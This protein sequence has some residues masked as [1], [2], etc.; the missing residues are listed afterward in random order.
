MMDWEARLTD[1]VNTYA[2][3]VKITP[4][5]WV[6]FRMVGE[7]VVYRVGRIGEDATLEFRAVFNPDGKCRDV[8]PHCGWA[9]GGK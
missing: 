8:C 5:T 3:G 2:S 6:E 7:F 4:D 9:E 1:I